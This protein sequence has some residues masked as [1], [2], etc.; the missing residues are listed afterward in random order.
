MKIHSLQ[1]E[2][3]KMKSKRGH[4][5]STTFSRLLE[6]CSVDL[7][8]QTVFK[9]A[10]TNGKGSVTRIL[11]QILIEDGYK[12]G[13]FYSPHLLDWR[14][15]IQINHE[16]VPLSVVSI[17]YEKYLE[18]KLTFEKENRELSFFENMLFLALNVFTTM[19]VDC[20]VLEAGLGARRDASY[21]IHSDVSI[22]TN[23]G[24][25]HAHILG[26]SREE[27]LYEKAGVYHYSRAGLFGDGQS[28]FKLL[29]KERET[30]EV[31]QL[32]RDH[33]K[34]ISNGL[35]GLQFEWR[36]EI[37][38]STMKGSHQAHNI[39]LALRALALSKLETPAPK[40][41]KSALMKL[42][43]PCRLSTLKYQGKTIL[44]DG[45]HNHEGWQTLL[46]F[47]EDQ[48]SS[49]TLALCLRKKKCSSE[50][51]TVFSQKE[52]DI[53]FRTPGPFW[54]KSMASDLFPRAK[55]CSSYAQLETAISNSINDLVVVTGSLIACARI[56]SWL[57][58]KLKS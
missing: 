5:E 45:G 56:E 24:T 40:L 53:A 48:R 39:A 37:Y 55:Y 30:C 31:E 7:S 3:R 51:L 15:R 26:E 52:P 57:K 19:R 21:R 6:S 28:L 10:G 8:G 36:G 12:V 13:S 16:F 58:K 2:I 44:F 43:H 9:V 54:T 34:I 27:I 14:E 25:D 49:Y 50:Q 20:I 4:Y 23:V 32:S 47:L 1:E 35:E 46:E 38:R 11:S 33:A 29:T 41:I 42:E 18:R 22:L 17:V